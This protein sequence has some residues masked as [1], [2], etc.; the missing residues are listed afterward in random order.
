MAAE[1]VLKRTEKGMLQLFPEIK[2]IHAQVYTF[3]NR[4][5]ELIR[6]WLM[7]VKA[8]FALFAFYISTQTFKLLNITKRC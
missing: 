3:K 6:K 4:N 1:Y 8:P 7:E 5:V 2:D